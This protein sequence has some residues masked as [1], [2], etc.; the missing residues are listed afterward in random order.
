[1]KNPKNPPNLRQIRVFGGVKV[2][3]FHCV[4]V[5]NVKISLKTL[6]LQI[7][8]AKIQLELLK[9]AYKISF[10]K[11]EIDLPHR[12]I[13]PITSCQHSLFQLNPIGFVT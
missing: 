10:Y 8:T 13:L 1:M 9:T 2:A 3:I 6:K 5:K 7:K 4:T 12:K 11:L